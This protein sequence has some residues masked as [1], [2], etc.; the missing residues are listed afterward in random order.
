MSSRLFVPFLWGNS[1][2]GLRFA[3]LRADDVLWHQGTAA[4]CTSHQ[5]W[6]AQTCVTGGKK[7]CLDQVFQSIYHKID[8]LLLKSL[9]WGREKNQTYM[10]LSGKD[11]TEMS[12]LWVFLPNVFYFFFYLFSNFATSGEISGLIEVFLPANGRGWKTMEFFL[13]MC[14]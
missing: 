4:S 11:L 2:E 10:K 3:V 1:C 14:L 8:F 12:G 7:T 5:Q 9:L 13:T 6:Q